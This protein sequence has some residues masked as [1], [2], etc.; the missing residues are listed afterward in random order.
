MNPYNQIG[1]SP[2]EELRLACLDRAVQ[3]GSG[4]LNPQEILSAARDFYNFVCAGV[5]PSS[6]DG[7]KG[8]SGSSGGVG[9]PWIKPAS[10]QTISIT[11]GD[12][13]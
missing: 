6:R 5:A 8:C 4:Y 11:I 13:D 2:V 3:Y 7:E 1:H 12:S 10:G 9:D